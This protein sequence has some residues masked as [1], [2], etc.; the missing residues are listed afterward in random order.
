MYPGNVGHTYFS[1]CNL[2]FLRIRIAKAFRRIFVVCKMQERL[3]VFG[4]GEQMA[5]VG[6]C[7]SLFAPS[8]QDFRLRQKSR[9]LLNESPV[10]YCP[11][12]PDA[13]NVPPTNFCSSFSS[14]SAS[15]PISCFSAFCSSLFLSLS[16]LA[17]SRAYTT[18]EQRITGWPR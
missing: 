8:E 7:H 13:L 4:D 9:D 17:F 6:G 2:K 1:V 15:P 11:Q 5:H 10:D 14:L 3:G 12:K 18:R 16:P